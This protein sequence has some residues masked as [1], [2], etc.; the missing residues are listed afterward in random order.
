MVSEALLLSASK[1]DKPA[2][3]PKGICGNISRIS[4]A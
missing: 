2:K 4:L 3:I 1:R